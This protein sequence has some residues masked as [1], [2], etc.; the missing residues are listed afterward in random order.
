MKIS[1]KITAIALVLTVIVLANYLAAHLPLRVDATAGG[2]YSLSTGTKTLLSRLETPVTLNFYFSKDVAGVH[3]SYKNYASRVQELLRQY[4]RASSG[5]ITLNIINPKPDTP[6]EKRAATAGIQPQPIAAT[7]ETIYL[8]IVAI[9]ADQEKS[10]PALTPQ[11]EPFLEY[12]I[13][14]LIHSVQA[15]DK[16]H[17]GLITSLP[18][19]G[20]QPDMRMM[21]MQ[22]QANAPAPQFV[23]TE[24]ERTHKIVP[25]DPAAQELP[26]GLASL[27]IIHPQ[28][29]SEKLEYAIDQFLLS[30]HPVFVAVDPSS[31]AARRSSSQQPVFMAMAPQNTAS[32]LPRLLKAWG[33]SYDSK[34]VVGDLKLAT[35]VNTGRSVEHYPV[36]LSLDAQNLNHNAQPT[37]QL[38]SL[39]FVES[40]SLSVDTSQT[41]L[42][43]TP[44]AESSEQAGKIPGTSLAM[45]D[46][47]SITR[48]L[49]PTGKKL[50]AVQLTGKFQTAFPHGAP[51][52]GEIPN[53]P[54]PDTPP[55]TTHAQAKPEPNQLKEGSSTIIVF[56]D[57]DWLFDDFSIRRLSLLGREAVQPL[58]DNLSLASNIA[59]IISGSTDL[60]SLRGKTNTERPFTVVRDL[61]AEAQKKYQA[62]LSGLE[63]RLETVQSK[64]AELLGKSSEGNRIV[65]TPEL[66]KMIEDFQ[67]QEIEMRSEHS[68]IRRSLREDIDALEYRLA[69]INLLS[70]P[71]LILVGALL[72]HRHRRKQLTTPQNTFHTHRT[73]N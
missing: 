37:S 57:T 11:R 52:G 62:K 40:G 31:D 20:R 63:K 21:M 42:A 53:T 14:Q 27:A 33:V 12:D 29:L 72:F 4:V 64:L 73:S 30:G 56:A 49:S 59:D 36:W 35:P 66:Q 70:M 19:A 5:K 1:N 22:P 46:P 8:G 17:L 48:Q 15:L 26:L 7:H 68:E 61:Q 67:K 43:A 28:G 18:L 25:V 47:A 32:D 54:K 23:Y 16:P 13:S 2:V 58:N 3:T 44:L 6:E 39:L 55:Q 41:G 50:L 71:I 60:V 51:N 34:E 24:W 9:Q 38:S 10:I 45:P 69:A 65:A